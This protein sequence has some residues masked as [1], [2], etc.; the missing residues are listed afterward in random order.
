MKDLTVVVGAGGIG[1]AIARRISSDRHILVANHSQE[2]A[3][4]AAKTLS[5]AGFEV[6]AMH[7]DVSER[8]MVQAVVRK[9]RNSGLSRP[10]CKLRG[11]HHHRPRSNLYSRSISMAPPCCWKNSVRS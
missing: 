7:A 8:E 11:C 3:D 2:S 6:T 5:D 10:W 1:Q 4:A 9:A